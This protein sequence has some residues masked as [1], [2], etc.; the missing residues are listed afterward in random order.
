MRFYYAFLLC[1]L[2]SFL[3]INYIMQDFQ[4]PNL[5]LWRYQIC[6]KNIIFVLKNSNVDQKIR[7]TKKQFK[8]RLAKNC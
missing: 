2:L 7:Q 8:N 1:V 4:I 3:F 5:R 6:E